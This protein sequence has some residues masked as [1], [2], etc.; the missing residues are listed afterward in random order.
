M[1]YPKDKEVS[2]AAVMV[3]M[4]LLFALG[5]AFNLVGLICLMSAHGFMP[6]LIAGAIFCGLA[7]ILALVG[8][9][10]SAKL[11]KRRRHNVEL[12]E[13]S[14]QVN[15]NLARK[16]S[17]NDGSNSIEVAIAKAVSNTFGAENVQVINANG[18]INVC[19]DGSA[20][21]INSLIFIRSTLENLIRS[22]SRGRC[23]LAR[24]VRM[25]NQVFFFW[26]LPIDEDGYFA[27]K[28]PIY[29]ENGLA[30]DENGS[31]FNDICDVPCFASHVQDTYV[32]IDLDC[33]ECNINYGIGDTRH[34]TPSI[35]KEGDT[36]DLNF[37]IGSSS[38][39]LDGRN[40]NLQASST[41]VRST[42]KVSHSSPQSNGGNINYGIFSSQKPRR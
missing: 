40:V 6:D 38:K 9:I 29:D 33:R 2:V 14:S 37:G 7:L 35:L 21:K 34:N 5:G 27:G 26:S 24:R 36:I 19:F 16:V 12:R 41:S 32:W 1:S 4:V 8:V 39:N 42:S 15:K 10:L 20:A 25:I 11:K 30:R 17:S 28:Y 22:I 31:L 23:C 18:T 3:P 13:K